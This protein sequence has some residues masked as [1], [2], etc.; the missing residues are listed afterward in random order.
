MWDPWGL[1]AEELA[2][3]HDLKKLKVYLSIFFK[4]V[5]FVSLK[6]DNSSR[7][8]DFPGILEMLLKQFLDPW[9]WLRSHE[10]GNMDVKH[11]TDTAPLR[12]SET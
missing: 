12:S 7:V 5:Y 11:W 9:W 1:T 8:H 6:F 4:N 2:N 3:A 10:K